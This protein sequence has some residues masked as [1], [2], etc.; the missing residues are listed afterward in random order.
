MWFSTLIESGTDLAVAA[1]GQS[2]LLKL[3]GYGILTG[4]VLLL[5]RRIITLHALARLRVPAELQAARAD[6]VHA[7]EVEAVKVKPEEVIAILVAHVFLL[8]AAGLDL[9]SD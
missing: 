5:T 9:I 4:I 6:V 3:A 1:S 7:G 8:T 2:K